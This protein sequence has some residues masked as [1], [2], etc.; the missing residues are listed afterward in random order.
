MPRSRRTERAHLYEGPTFRAIQRR[1][2]DRVKKLRNAAKL[3]Q[4]DAAAKC[5]LD[6][7][8][9][10]RVERLE[11]NLTLTTL[12]RLVDGFQVDVSELFAATPKPKVNNRGSH[13]DIEN[14][15]P[16]VHEQSVDDLGPR[17]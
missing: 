7:R 13:R 8:L 4:E 12:A 16:T 17:R 14:E 11:S 1:V 2:A 6:V 5:G 15:H 9:Y 10:Q 3:S